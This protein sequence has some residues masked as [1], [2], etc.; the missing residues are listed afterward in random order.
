M[1]TS[2]TGR[3]RKN[4]LQQ[5]RGRRRGT[6]PQPRRD[7]PYPGACDRLPGA[8]QATNH[9][10]ERERPVSLLRP[11]GPHFGH[12]QGVDTLLYC[13]H[14]GKHRRPYPGCSLSSAHL[15]NVVGES[16]TVRWSQAVGWSVRRL[17]PQGYLQP[18]QKK[19]SSKS[20]KRGRRGRRKGNHGCFSSHRQIHGD[21][22]VCGRIVGV[23]PGGPSETMP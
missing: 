11:T 5:D 4:F 18:T 9:I 19:S 16:V 13:V 12:T 22:R 20:G 10:K 6:P 7:N 21:G 3:G 17:E 2:S 15:G 1:P 14:K 8:C 23:W